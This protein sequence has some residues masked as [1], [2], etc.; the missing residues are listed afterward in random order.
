MEGW[1][2]GFIRQVIHLAFRRGQRSLGTGG[3]LGQAEIWDSLCGGGGEEGE[4]A[5]QLGGHWVLDIMHWGAVKSWSSLRNPDLSIYVVSIHLRR[6]RSRVGVG[7]SWG[8]AAGKRGVLW[9]CGTVLLA[10]AKP[11]NGHLHSA[12][13]TSGSSSYSV[14]CQDQLVFPGILTLERS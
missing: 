7:G 13:R 10:W 5:T 14:P 1:G 6:W 11:R 4:E 8:C 9:L 3:T 12:H 2:Q